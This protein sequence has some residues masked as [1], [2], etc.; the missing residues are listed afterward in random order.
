VSMDEQGGNLADETAEMMSDSVAHQNEELRKRRSTRIMQAVPLAVTGVDALGRPFTERTSTLIINCHGCRYQSKHYVLKNMWVTLEVPHP[1]A[2]QLPRTVRGRVAWIQRPRTVRQLFQIALELETPGNAW[3]IAFP[4]PDW[5]APQ[6][7][8]RTSGAYES[9][10]ELPSRAS[11]PAEIH[12]P[13][14]EPETAAA[15]PQPQDNLR[16]FPAP[17]SATDASLQLA[18]HMARLM[19]DAKQQIQAA[20]REVAAQAVAAERRV[21]MEE[22]DQRISVANEQL[23]ENLTAAIQT[24]QDESEL[25]SRAANSAAAEAL[26]RDLPGWIAPQLEQLTRELT[27]QLSD[28]GTA[29]RGEQAQHLARAVETL[30]AISKQAEETAAQLRV[31][32]EQSH[33]S[34]SARAAEAV[35]AVEEVARQ[36]E[37]TAQAHREAMSAAAVEIQQQVSAVTSAAHASW[38]SQISSETEAA[39]ARWRAT[40]ESTLGEAQEKAATGLSEQAGRLSSQAQEE[41]ARQAAA[42]RESISAATAEAEQRA[43]ALNE[44]VR[45]H[46]LQVQEEAAR[47]AAALRESLSGPTVEVEQRVAEVNGQLRSVVSQ[48]LEEGERR[49]GAIRES[50]NSAAAEAEQRVAGLNEQVRSNLSQAQEDAAR[51]AAAIRESISG[52][53]AE[54]EQ[55]MAGANEQLRSMLSQMQE[56]AGRQAALAGGSVSAAAVEAEQRMAGLQNSLHEKSQQLDGAVARA[57]ASSERLEHLSARIET[58]QNRALAAFETQID[59]VLTLHRNELH[60]RSETQLEEINGRIRAT[61]DEYCQQALSRFDQQV[62]SMVEPHVSRTEQA[63]H[64]LAGGR[65][66]LDAAMTLQQDRIRTSADEAFAESLARFRENLGGVDELLQE[67]AQTVAARNLAEIESK[68]SAV[69]HQAVDDLMK[70]AEW[71]EKKAQTQIQSLTEKTVELAENQFREKAGEVSSVFASELDHSSRSFIGHTQTQMDDVVR[72]AFN[73]ARALFAEAAETTTAAFTDEIQR[74]ARQELDGFGEE[75]QRS[76]GETRTQLDVARA[77]MAHKVTDEQET[78]LRE[79]RKRMTGAV[80]AGVVDAREKV[81]SGMSPLLN[82][83][84]STVEEH[85][86]QMSDIYT[87]LSNQASEQHRNRLEN[88]STQWL[89]ATV[90]SL[91]HQSREAAARI[92]V[93]AEE[94]LRETCAQVFAGVGETLQ[95]RLQ[96]IAAT[97]TMG[98]PPITRSTTAGGTDR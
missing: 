66:L 92:A 54:A 88:V 73:Q 96:Q 90:A 52:T 50:A 94:K 41:A 85:R 63:I 83:W 97:L 51:Q 6:E 38:Q 11:E 10:H 82:A 80:E 13:L 18:R 78:F 9:G 20:A 47:Q 28:R 77:E 17:A 59:D 72:D 26:R 33:A 40:V 1:E 84:K 12:L 42:T 65:S 93:N 31:Q 64:R 57:A 87:Q 86:L 14:T 60:R 67:A 68:A 22:W 27:Q 45:N 19:A 95:Q 5:F 98:E 21:S 37:V 53:A 56:E 39:Q 15:V 74:Q 91:D 81:Q 29:E 71:Y 79:F 75:A 24:I 58:A 44:Q 76:L 61:F 32:A 8:V 4:P 62:E 69:K 55:R 70:S 25:S 46:F 48:V 23:S 35:R 3:G 89:L 7:V 2:G 43:A 16:V 30:A 49:A 36:R 34:I